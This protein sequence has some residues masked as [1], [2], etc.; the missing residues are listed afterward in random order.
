M[1]QIGI[2]TLRQNVSVLEPMMLDF[3]GKV[4]G[5]TTENP[6]YNGRRTGSAVELPSAMYVESNQD[7]YDH[8]KSPNGI[9]FVTSTNASGNLTQQIYTFNVLE[10]V[11]RK[12]GSH[13]TREW[14]TNNIAEIEGKFLGR[15][16]VGV[17]R[18]VTF[19]IINEGQNVWWEGTSHSSD[20]YEY[21]TVKTTNVGRITQD[22]LLHF[23]AYSEK[24]NEIQGATLACDYISCRVIFKE[25]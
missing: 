14:L 5:S 12:H 20:N 11:R 23:T 19:S 22:G 4:A 1:L 7:Y 8:I 9:L 16:Y 24:A 6:H 2:K 21:L 3:Y 18:K 25:V 15:G 17:N 13:I 10:A